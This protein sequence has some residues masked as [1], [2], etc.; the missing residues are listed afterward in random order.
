MTIARVEIALCVVFGII[1]AY[2]GD[3]SAALVWS[4]C[5]IAWFNCD[6]VERRCKKIGETAV[7]IANQNKRVLGMNKRLIDKSEIEEKHNHLLF[8]RMRLAENDADFCKHKK[9][10]SD[11]ISFKQNTE[12][13]IEDVEK[14]L[15]KM[16]DEYYK[17]Y[18]EDS[19]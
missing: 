16:I 12:E 13:E 15:S 18:M 1:H 3:I 10:S 17:T 7:E 4:I 8:L 9:S 14:G 5:I 2:I 6:Y 11:Y 19:L